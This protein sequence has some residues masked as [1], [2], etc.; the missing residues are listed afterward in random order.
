MNKREIDIYT[1]GLFDGEG[2][3]TMILPS[4]T[5]VTKVPIIIVV[6]TDYNLLDFLRTNYGGHIYKRIKSK[7][8]LHNQVWQWGLYGNKSLEFLEKIFPYMKETN[9]IY[10]AK[11]LINGY[12]KYIKRGKGLTEKDHI[13]NN[14]FYNEFFAVK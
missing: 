3:I 14:N 7:N 4:K 2:S 11:L 13:N 5:N 10:R 6:N 12:K 1:A 8:L 9:K